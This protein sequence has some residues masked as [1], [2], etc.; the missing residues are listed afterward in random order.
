MSPCRKQSVS[1]VAWGR[2]WVWCDWVNL[3]QIVQ[4]EPRWD[5]FSA[6]RWLDTRFPDFKGVGAFLACSW[7]GRMFPAVGFI[8]T[9]VFL[10]VSCVCMLA[11]A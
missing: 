8:G 1:Q 2:C 9:H 11:Q 5:L 4:D 6:N 7:A 3:R 10:E